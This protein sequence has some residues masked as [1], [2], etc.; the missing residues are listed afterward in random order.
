M[1]TQTQKPSNG[2]KP[3]TLPTSNGKE[4]SNTALVVVPKETPKT[5]QPPI[6]KRLEKFYQLEKVLERREKIA[7]AVEELSNFYIAPTG[8]GCNLKLQDSKGNTFAISHP[9]VIGEIVNMAKSKLETELNA[10]NEE[11]SFTI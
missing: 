11:F 10:I 1:S 6:E 7:E 4:V 9:A 3:Q 2:T 5:E 8:T